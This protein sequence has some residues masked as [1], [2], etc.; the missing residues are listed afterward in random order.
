MALRSNF[1]L[2]LGRGVANHNRMG[3]S[4]RK[5]KTGTQG[6]RGGGALARVT[7]SPLP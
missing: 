7:P 3:D 4:Y 6:T 5:K 1:W 2:A